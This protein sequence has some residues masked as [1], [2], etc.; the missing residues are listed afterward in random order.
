MPYEFEL[1]KSGERANINDVDKEVAELTHA[2]MSDT[3]YT[4]GFV[5]VVL[6]CRAYGDHLYKQNKDNYD[7]IS[8]DN[9]LELWLKDQKGTNEN[10]INLVKN[11][12][13]KYTLHILRF[14]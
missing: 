8:W 11:V 5:Y 7:T 13:S 10:V 14:C 1:L 3:D 6:I 2:K 4:S 12:L 9:D